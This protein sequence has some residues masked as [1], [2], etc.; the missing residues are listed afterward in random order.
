MGALHDLVTWYGINYA[1]T[2]SHTVLGLPKQRNSY[3]SSP[4]FL[5]F[6]SRPSIINSVQ[7]DRIMQRAYYISLPIMCKT[8]PY[9]RSN[10]ASFPGSLIFPH[11]SNSRLFRSRG[12]EDEWPWEL[13]WCRVFFA[14]VD[15]LQ[16][17][18]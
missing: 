6:E 11:L 9:Q 14:M 1:G 7:C 17:N 18:C 16:I 3:Q 5:C 13:G 15:S 12:R 4:T 10:T 8:Y 2:H